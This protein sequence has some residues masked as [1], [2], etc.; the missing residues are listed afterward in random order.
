EMQ[1][2]FSGT[3][4]FPAPGNWM[5]IILDEPFQWDGESNIVVA[6]DENSA[7]TYFTA[8]FRSFT[9]EANTGLYRRVAN[10]IDPANPGAALPV[11]TNA[12]RT[13]TLSQIA[14]EAIETPDCMPVTG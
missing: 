13:A 1:Q 4:T 3:V 7:G 2:S 12:I 9:S 14:F 6:V 8:Y 10:D 5:E 11:A